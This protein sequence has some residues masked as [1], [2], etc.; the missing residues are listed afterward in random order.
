M[1]LNLNIISII[2]AIRKKIAG[3]KQKKLEY[4][5]IFGHYLLNYCLEINEGER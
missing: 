5:S 1:H 3:F 2:L 4:V